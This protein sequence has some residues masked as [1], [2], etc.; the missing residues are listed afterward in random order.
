MLRGYMYRTKHRNGI[1]QVTLF[2]NVA[3]GQHHRVWELQCVGFLGCCRER[4]GCVK[5]C[6]SHNVFYSQSV[7]ERA[8]EQ[9]V[10]VTA[11]SIYRVK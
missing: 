9:S 11:C 5:E 7:A 2:S 8:M 1:W 6:W 10:G 4:E 3:N